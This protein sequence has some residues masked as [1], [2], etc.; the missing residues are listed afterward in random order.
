MKKI[1]LAFLTALGLL[2]LSACGGGSNSPSTPTHKKIGSDTLYVKKVENMPEDFVI[3]MDSSSV[4]SLEESGVKY[5]DF[6]GKEQDLFKILS[7]VGITH[8]RVRIWNDPFDA[9]GHGYGGGNVNID[10][11]VEIGKRVTKYGMKLLANFHYSDFWADPGRQLAPKAWAGKSLEEKCQLLYDYTYSCMQKFKAAGVDVGIVQVGNETNIGIA[12]ETTVAGMEKFSKL[13]TQGTR[14][15]KAVYPDA[16]TA[17]HFTNPEKGTYSR[18]ASQLQTYK[19]EYDIFGTS[20]YPF[21]HGTMDN[22]KKQLN[23]VATV[24]GKKVMVLETSYAYNSEDTDFCGNQFDEYS[25]YP[26]AY[27][28]SPSGQVNNFRNICDLMV[29]GLNIVD[30]ER[31]GLGVCYW[32][33]TWIGVGYK[34]YEENKEKWNRYGSGWASD[35]AAEYDP[36]VA[37]YGGGGT[38]VENQCFFDKN[39]KAL[40]QLKMF[41][42][43]RDGNVTEEFIDGVSTVTVEHKINETFTLPETAPA[44]YNSDRRAE[45]PATWENVDL[46][47]LK[48]QGPGT[49]TINGTCCGKQTTCYLVLKAENFVENGSFESKLDNWTMSYLGDHQPT[50]NGATGTSYWVDSAKDNVCKDGG[51]Y[52]LGWWAKDKGVV[53]FEAKQTISA[54]EDDTYRL[55]FEYIGGYSGA[56][57][58]PSDKQNNYASIL[59]NGEEQYHI[60]FK[61]TSWGVDGTFA[62]AKLDNIVLNASDT[63]ELVFHVEADVDGYWG[64]VDA[65]V[66]YR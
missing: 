35:Y 12:G 50:K 40:E 6:D 33:G 7:D 22:L 60:D 4:L 51:S 58:V 42:L 46:D 5:Y 26:K 31:P 36:E 64:A 38:V 57:D 44:I 49:Y 14:A 41:G 56:G 59:V 39:G 34:S 23:S 62:V 19:C 54:T 8:V 24:Y 48:A 2:A 1:K 47:A 9:E 45:Q 66:V 3:G 30:D 37:S 29:N 21:F 13:V 52:S 65:V 10:R 11:A 15:V 27:P 43:M 20:Y 18:T 25:S 28:I 16:L 32:E 55:A 61:M 63:N 53:N 17:V